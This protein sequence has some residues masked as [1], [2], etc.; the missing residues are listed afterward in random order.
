M[1]VM[2]PSPDLDE[3]TRERWAFILGKHRLERYD[4]EEAIE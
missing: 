4:G 3:D 2:S 1:N